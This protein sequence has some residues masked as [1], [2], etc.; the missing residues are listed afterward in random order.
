MQSTPVRSSDAKASMWVAALAFAVAAFALFQ[1]RAG[2]TALV[3]MGCGFSLLFVRLRQERDADDARLG[4][5][6]ELQRARELL[7]RGAHRQ[8]LGVAHGVAELARSEPLQRRALE[9]L[10]WCELGLGRPQ[11]AQNALSWASGAGT[12][13]PY[14]CAAVEDA[15]G[16]GLWAL[17]IMERAARKRQLSREATL[18][19][20]ELYARLRGVEAAC[21]LTLA[22]LNRLLPEDAERV[23]RFAQ[24][25]GRDSNATLALAQALAKLQSQGS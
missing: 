15:C 1:G 11:A 3:A 16:H 12:L 6:E 23:L 14:C 5:A 7:G 18:F 4:L 13:D 10:A 2:L 20:I 17:H 9:L 25:A 21:Q 24:A 8:A 22:Q 19:R